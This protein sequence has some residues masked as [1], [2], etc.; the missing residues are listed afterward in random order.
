MRWNRSFRDKEFIV[1]E[2]FNRKRKR[3][4]AGWR[5]VQL[6]CIFR[7]CFLPPILYRAWNEEWPIQISGEDCDRRIPDCAKYGMSVLG[8]KTAENHENQ[9]TEE[10]PADETV[11]MWWNRAEWSERKGLFETLGAGT[12]KIGIGSALEEFTAGGRKKG[13]ISFA[14]ARWEPEALFK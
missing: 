6:C 14:P 8:V 9:N 13:L 10:Q 3:K 1:E 11:L 7:F 5:S 4:T 12:Y 2:S